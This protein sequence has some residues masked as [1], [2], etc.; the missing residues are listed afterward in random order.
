[1]ASSAKKKRKKV[2]S[3]IVAVLYHPN[4]PIVSAE[5]PTITVNNPNTSVYCIF[6][7]YIFKQSNNGRY[8]ARPQYASYVPYEIWRK[9]D[10]VPFHMFSWFSYTTLNSWTLAAMALLFFIL[11]REC[12][13]CVFTVGWC[14]VRLFTKCRIFSTQTDL[15]FIQIFFLFVCYQF[16]IVLVLNG[17]R[18]ASSFYGNTYVYVI[19]KHFY[20]W[21]FFFAIIDGNGEIF[22]ELND[23]LKL[24]IIILN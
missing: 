19:E 5:W 24:R 23:T 11:S 10:R 6:Y 7:Y 1:M 13:D 15:Q 3:S 9:S 20:E 8:R 12:L 14:C 17:Y 22:N 4:W 21:D 16:T 2:F 18:L